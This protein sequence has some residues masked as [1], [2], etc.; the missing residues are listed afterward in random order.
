MTGCGP[1]PVD[2]GY[3][4]D[5]DPVETGSIEHLWAGGYTPVLNTLG[6]DP[7]RPGFRADRPGVRPV[8]N[9]NADTV[10]SPP[11]PR[12]WAPTTCS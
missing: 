7:A 11:S 5:L 8:Y 2:F 9:I 6:L 12:R 10:A 3:V 4:G 1:D